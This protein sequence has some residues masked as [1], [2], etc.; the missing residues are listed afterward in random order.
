MLDIIILF[1]IVT[2]FIL[3]PESV[4]IKFPKLDYKIFCDKFTGTWNGNDCICKQPDFITNNHYNGNCDKVV[5]S[6]CKRILNSEGNLLNFNIEN[7]YTEGVCDCGKYYVYDILSHKCVLRKLNTPSQLEENCEDG[8]YFDNKYKTCLK[9][10][11]FWDI[12]NPQEKIDQSTISPTKCKCNFENGFAP[13]S[14]V[15]GTVG[16]TRVLRGGAWSKNHIILLEKKHDRQKISHLYP[17][18]ALGGGFANLVSDNDGDSGAFMF[19]IEQSHGDWLKDLHSRGL[20]IDSQGDYDKALG[21]Y[22]STTNK[23]TFKIKNE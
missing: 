11:C 19:S 1:V 7:P 8:Y 14:L 4:Q 15:N 13:I 18:S 17:L 22:D 23:L 10:L 20:I 6:N 5:D 21:F 16:C 2:I 9:K 3:K 12:L